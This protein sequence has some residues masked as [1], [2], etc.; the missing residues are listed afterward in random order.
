[1]KLISYNFN[2]KRIAQIISD[3]R[4]YVI[5][6]IPLFIVFN[7]F[8]TSGKNFLEL[9]ILCLIFAAFLPFTAILMWIKNKNLDLDVSNKDERI[10]PLVI[11]II[12]SFMGV[13]TLFIAN[14]P[15]VIIVFMFCYFTTTLL[16]L[17]ITYFWKISVH[18]M[19]FAGITAAITYV[20]GYLG[21][22]LGFPLI[23][24]MWSRIYLQK[25]TPAQVVV[26]AATSLVF[27]WAQ[28]TILLS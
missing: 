8:T 12:S 7:Y 16:I 3:I 25:H 10:F 18:A 13:V 14:A 22:F 26:G 27:T 20:F 6:I 5:L 11:G 19:G 1:M 2:I 28:F 15:A 24:V 17:S 23:L 4:G 21:L 9:T